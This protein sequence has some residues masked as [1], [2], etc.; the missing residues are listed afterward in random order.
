MAS[1]TSWARNMSVKY[2]LAHKTS[3]VN[4]NV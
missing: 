1:V 4:I 2:L 3:L